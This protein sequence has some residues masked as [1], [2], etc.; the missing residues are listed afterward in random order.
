MAGV[1]VQAR[2]GR[3]DHRTFADHIRERKDG[4]DPLD[5]ANGQCLCGQ[6]HTLKTVAARAE[7]EAGQIIGAFGG[8]NRAGGT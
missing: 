4:G 5:P 1:G 7:G 6:H 2:G 3:G 8:G